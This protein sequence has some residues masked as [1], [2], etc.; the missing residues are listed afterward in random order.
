MRNRMRGGGVKEVTETFLGRKQLDS[1][2]VRTGEDCAW[3]WETSSGVSQV[4]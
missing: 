1:T 3:M 4:V 2:E